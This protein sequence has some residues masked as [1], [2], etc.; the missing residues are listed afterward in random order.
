MLL[1][2]MAIWSERQ[3]IPLAGF[4]PLLRGVCG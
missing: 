3:S 4:W 2:I 1:D